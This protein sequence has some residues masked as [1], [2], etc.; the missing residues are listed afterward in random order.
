MP[1][2][3]AM[4]AHADWVQKLATALVGKSDADDVVQE[5][6]LATMLSPP[7]SGTNVRGWLATVVQNFA[8]QR[9]RTERRRRAREAQR[10]R[11]AELPSSE[12]ACNDSTVLDATRSPSKVLVYLVRLSFAPGLSS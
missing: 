8:R 1:T 6:W 2:V 4:L 5:T 12:T 11:A 10:T 3:Q 9:Q 7:Q